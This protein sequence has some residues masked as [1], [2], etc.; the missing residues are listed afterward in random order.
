M[1]LQVSPHR[2]QI[3]QLA[4]VIGQVH[5]RGHQQAAVECIVQFF[6]R[7][8]EYHFGNLLPCGAQSV[9]DLFGRC[10]LCQ[11]ALAFFV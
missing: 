4:P 5:N 2:L 8:R 3:R 7:G 9:D 6:L 1:I 10:C 11:N